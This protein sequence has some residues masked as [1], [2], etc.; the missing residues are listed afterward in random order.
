MHTRDPVRRGVEGQLGDLVSLD[1]SN[2][3]EFPGAVSH[4]RLGEGPTCQK[5]GSIHHRLKGSVPVEDVAP[6]T[7]HI[8]RQSPVFF[9]TVGQARH[10][11]L[12]RLPASRCK[13]VDVSALGDPSP[14]CSPHDRQGIPLNQGHTGEVRG[15][16]VGSEQP[17]HAGAYDNGMP[18]QSV[19]GQCVTS[20]GSE[21]KHGHGSPQSGDC[22][23]AAR[24]G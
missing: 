16:C 5:G 4:M 20:F 8:G 7:Q 11:L 6:L 18:V 9:E 13:D 10:E 22:C 2:V 24:M 12:Y 23:D 21:V 15:Q 3:A 1:E 14:L 17:G 19:A